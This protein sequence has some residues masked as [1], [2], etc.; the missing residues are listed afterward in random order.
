MRTRK[1]L[2][3]IGARK[4]KYTGRRTERHILLA[5]DVLGKALP[6]GVQ[7]HHFAEDVLVICPNQAYHSLLH[8]RQRAVEAGHPVDYRKCPYCKKFDS[9][10]NMLLIQVS[11]K[12]PNGTAIHKQCRIDYLKDLK[13][14]GSW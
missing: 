5:E 12:T 9:L 3:K 2:H 10:N 11:L 14:N 6:I 4:S 8:M 1:Q 7:V 13:L